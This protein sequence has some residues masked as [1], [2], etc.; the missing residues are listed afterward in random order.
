MHKFRIKIP[1]GYPN[2][3]PTLITSLPTEINLRWFAHSGSLQSVL[4]QFQDTLKGYDGLWSELAA[5]DRRAWVL[6]PTADMWSGTM[7]R[8]AITANTSIQVILDAAHPRALPECHQLGLDHTVAPLRACF[9]ASASKWNVKKQVRS[10]SALSC[11]QPDL[12]TSN[13]T[14]RGPLLRVPALHSA[15]P[16]L[17]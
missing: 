5:F 14:C 13:S 11:Q 1:Q 10:V 15:L 9:N 4:K 12:P 16:S 3:P 7:R 8:V 6:E 2:L 17:S